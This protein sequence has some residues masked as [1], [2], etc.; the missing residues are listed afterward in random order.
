MFF[1][2]G[3]AETDYLASRD[4]VLGAAIDRIGHIDRE[5][6]TLRKTVGKPHDNTFPQE[7]PSHKNRVTH[8]Q[9]VGVAGRLVSHGHFHLH[10]ALLQ[11]GH[12]PAG[13]HGSPTLALRCIDYQDSHSSLDF[14]TAKI[15]FFDLKKAESHIL[16]LILHHFLGWRK[17]ATSFSQPTKAIQPHAP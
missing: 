4:P 5:K 12:Q 2:Y 11:S 6:M 17:R 15:P 16:F 14:Y 3:R 8:R 1:S 13:G 10:A 9:H 7:A